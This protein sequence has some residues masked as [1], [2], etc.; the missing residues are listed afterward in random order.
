[1]IARRAPDKLGCLLWPCQGRFGGFTEKPGK[2]KPIHEPLAER[3][4]F[5]LVPDMQPRCNREL[6]GC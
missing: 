2:A 3:E 4:G 5:E 1:M 6:D